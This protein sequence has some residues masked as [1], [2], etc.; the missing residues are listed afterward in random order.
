[1]LLLIRSFLPLRFEPV[2]EMT[3][4]PWFGDIVIFSANLTFSEMP[5]RDARGSFTMF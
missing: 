2:R 4:V 1:M 5:S 3:K